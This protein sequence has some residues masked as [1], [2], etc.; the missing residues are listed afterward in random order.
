MI[1]GMV[2]SSGNSLLSKQKT[3]TK[4]I[5][6]VIAMNSSTKKITGV[7]AKLCGQ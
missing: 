7:L 4:F 2:F 6:T 3:V 5:S 1:P